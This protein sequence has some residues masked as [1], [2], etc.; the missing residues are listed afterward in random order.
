[1][2]DD[3]PEHDAVVTDIEGQ[4]PPGLVGNLYRNGPGRRSYSQH[5]FDGDG[6]IRRL[7]FS[8]DGSVRYTSRFVHT[9]RYLA[10]QRAGR[11]LYR[12]AGTPLPGGV[13][14]N[15]LRMPH[16]YANTTA[17]VRDGEMWAL[18][19][20]GP[21]FRI[22]PG[23]LETL[24]VERFGGALN[25]KAPVSAHPHTDPNTG[26][27]YNFG[28]RPG[29][30]G[31]EIHSFKVDRHGRLHELARTRVSHYSFLHDFALTEHW[32][33]F[34]IPPVRARLAKMVLGFSTVMGAMD[35]VPGLPTQNYLV[36]RDGKRTLRFET[37]PSIVGHVIAA[38][39]VGTEVV[40][41]T[42][43]IEDWD[44]AAQDMADH[45]T[46]HFASFDTIQ[47]WRYRF[48]TMTGRTRSEVLLDH[49]G[50]FP[51]SNERLPMHGWRYSYLSV[52]SAP[53]TGGLVRRHGKLD[54]QTGEF[55]SYD[56]GPGQVAHEN[57]FAP[58]PARQAEDGGWLLGFVYNSS[59]EATDAVVL[60]AE[61]VAEGPIATIRLPVSAGTT[62]HGCWVAG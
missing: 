14:K 31:P 41:D 25:A 54:L 6:M 28:L 48:D 49:P 62:F 59:R 1:M 32:M 16:S 40:V 39:E 24:G 17:F 5:Y 47:M 27:T 30:R 18:Y 2:W 52:N 34:S 12:G 36:S 61:R 20:S 43:R 50:D 9:P 15:A 10:E 33:W 37:D 51:R 23:S 42:V 35:V 45:R 4:L 29:V 46:T 19:E 7:R 60:D 3:A 53:R 13:L 57:V 8:A 55:E 22:D 11:R 56:Y 38:R 58:D 26:E 21:V 44:G